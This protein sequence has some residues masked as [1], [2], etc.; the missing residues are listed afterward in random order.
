MRI[1]A[2]ALRRIEPGP[3]VRAASLLWALAGSTALFGLLLWRFDIAA[4]AAPS[5]VSAVAPVAPVA[6]AA[7]AALSPQEGAELL[8]GERATVDLFRRASPSVVHVT[9]LGLYRNRFNRNVTE[10]PR[11]TGT[12]FLWDAEGHVVTNYHV[13]AGAPGSSSKVI[14]TLRDRQYQAKLIGH[15]EDRD[16]AVLELEHP[17]EGLRGLS[18]G[19]SENL[20]VGQSV[21]AIGNPF[22]LDQTLTTGVISGLG[23]EIRSLSDHKIRDVI[24][25]DAAINP[26]NSGGPLLDS[27][28]RLIGV[29]TAI[30]S[31]SGT[32]AGI[33]FAVPVDAVREVVPQ[34]IQHG[35]VTKP[36]LGVYL[37]EDRQAASLGLSGV[38]IEEVVGGTAA[39]RAGLRSM[40][41]FRDRTVALD[42]ILAVDGVRVSTRTDLFDI[43]DQREVGDRVEL[44]VRRGNEVALIPVRLQAIR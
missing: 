20:R 2:A 11:G 17:P 10:I 26:G 42:E 6:R 41:I 24:Q 5:A 40:Q 44:Q 13:I 28:G 33:G 38:G 15:S 4:W 19:S 8:P 9:N 23:R 39:D 37:M 27:H 7:P 14:V 43:L 22:G 30:M 35:R 1:H 29:N 32:Y 3:R 25:T 34:L 36:G 31:P 21:Y 18:L 12:G 16:L